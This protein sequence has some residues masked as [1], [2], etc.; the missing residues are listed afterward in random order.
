MSILLPVDLFFLELTNY[1]QTFFDTEACITFIFLATL[2]P[3][4]YT[5]H[6]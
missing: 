6:C 3:L 1:S 2:F 4:P 5:S